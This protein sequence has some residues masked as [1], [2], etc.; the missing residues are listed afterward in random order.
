MAVPLDLEF[1]ASVASVVNSCLVEHESEGGAEDKRRSRPFCYEIPELTT[2][3]TC[4]EFN[5]SRFYPVS[6]MTDHQIC[7]AY[8]YYE[9][10]RYNNSMY[11]VIS[12]YTNTICSV[13]GS[14]QCP[15]CP[16]YNG[17]V[18]K[19]PSLRLILVIL[20]LTLQH[21]RWAHE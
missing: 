18:L 21:D 16:D 20:L 17:V 5:A 15:Y 14:F 7:L 13:C 6:N 12:L 1:T 4:V 3:R 11:E 19:E 8:E 2:E 10:G 9:P